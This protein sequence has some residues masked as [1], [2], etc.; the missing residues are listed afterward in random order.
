MSTVATSQE[1][2]QDARNGDVCVFGAGA[3]IFTTSVFFVLLVTLVLNVHYFV[4]SG[5][6]AGSYTGEADS[7]SVDGGPEVVVVVGRYARETAAIVGAYGGGAADRC[8]VRCHLVPFLS[9]WRSASAVVLSANASLDSEDMSRFGQTRPTLVSLALDPPGLLAAAASSIDGADF[10]LR[11]SYHPE[12]SDI[13]V[14]RVSYRERNASASEDN[15][16]MP[17]ALPLRNSLS[18]QRLVATIM[19]ECSR[20]AM[21]GGETFL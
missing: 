2:R 6:S 8:D 4:G 16:R 5:S 1:R 13:P 11:V 3:K 14:A 18:G 10:D 21:R 12:A 19:D 15:H 17:G 7:L 20:S 9:D